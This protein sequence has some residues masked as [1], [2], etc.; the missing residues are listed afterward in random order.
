MLIGDMDITRLMIYVQQDEED[1]L[2][3][4]KKFKNKRAKTRNESGQQKRP[5]PSSASALVPKNKREYNSQ[6]FRA[7]PAYSQGSMAQGVVS[8]LPALSV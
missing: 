1:K 8:L 7:K 5:A 3:D 4:R 6:N 2:R